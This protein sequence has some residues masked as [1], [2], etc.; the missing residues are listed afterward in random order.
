MDPYLG[1]AA[2]R[3]TLLLRQKSHR[4]ADEQGAL[5]RHQNCPHCERARRAPVFS[6]H[7]K[8][9]PDGGCLAGSPLEK[10]TPSPGM[11]KP[12]K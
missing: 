9:S 5:V 4:R 8:D 1:H 3:S 12:C 10:L 6:A 11:H 7:A 2:L